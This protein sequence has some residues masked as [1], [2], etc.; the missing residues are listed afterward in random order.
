MKNVIM[1]VTYLLN[2]PIANLFFYCQVY[3]LRENDFLIETLRQSY[4]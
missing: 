2:G 4:P 3:I 1:Q